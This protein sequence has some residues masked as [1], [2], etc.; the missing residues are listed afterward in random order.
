ML[1]S[2]EGK[3]WVSPQPLFLPPHP[4]P[5]QPPPGIP[6]S[7]PSFLTWLLLPF[8]REC[9]QACLHYAT[10][11]CQ[12]SSGEGPKAQGPEPD[13]AHSPRGTRQT[14]TSPRPSTQSLNE[15]G[16]LSSQWVQKDR[17]HSLELLPCPRQREASLT[18]M[19][20]YLAH[21]GG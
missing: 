3:T 12:P 20:P 11:H 17:S 5:H 7:P 1:R 21:L 18:P 9:L 15:I 6:P 8:P 19:C 2:K 10:R 14:L 4:V 13:M 16:P